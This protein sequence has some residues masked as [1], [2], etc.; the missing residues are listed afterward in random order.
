[1]KDYKI[2]NFNILGGENS[3]LISLEKDKD[4]PFEIKRIYYIFNTAKDVERGFHAHKN[5]KQIV[6]AL[7]GSC[8]FILDDGYKKIDIKL[9][10][11]KKGI[12]IEGIIWREIKN[13]N[14]SCVLLV[15]ASENYDEN[16]YIRDYNE[17][18]ALKNLEK[19]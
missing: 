18:L 1:M 11:E 3:P 4:I 9:D 14:D 5:L 8:N 19:K 12:F 13:I 7:K 15:I 10:N 6:I 16:D 17:F 2:I